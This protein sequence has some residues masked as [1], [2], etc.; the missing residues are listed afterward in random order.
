MIDENVIID[1]LELLKR[2][3]KIVLGKHKY[4]DQISFEYLLNMLIDYINE[5]KE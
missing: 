1:K 5:H 2:N 4:I 3:S